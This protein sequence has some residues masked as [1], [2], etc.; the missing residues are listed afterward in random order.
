ME[1]NHQQP[2]AK[3]RTLTM[4]SEENTSKIG[5]AIKGIHRR[6]SS[7]GKFSKSH[8]SPYETYKALPS[9]ASA[10]KSSSRNSLAE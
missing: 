1:F 3:P 6:M 2:K 8:K 5:A 7:M 10:S 9:V 4:M